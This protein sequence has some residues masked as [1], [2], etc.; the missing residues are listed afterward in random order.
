MS[1]EAPMNDEG[2]VS[3]ERLVGRICGEYLEMPGLVLTREQA[4][5][6]WGLDAPTCLQ[7]LEGL[8]DLGFLMRRPNGRY[9][10]RTDGRVH[11]GSGLGPN[12]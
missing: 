2:V 8:V 3:H 7:L 1:E 4:Q 5:R 11:P 12:D 9:R 10:R 6:L